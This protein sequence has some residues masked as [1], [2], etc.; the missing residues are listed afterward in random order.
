MEN[1][2]FTMTVEHIG[3]LEGKHEVKA[4]Y[5]LITGDITGNDDK[6]WPLM[7][8]AI[9]RDGQEMKSGRMRSSFPRKE[10]YDMFLDLCLGVR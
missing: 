2:S 10:I 7:E 8:Y 9:T 6:N 1:G 3:W 5:H 4:T